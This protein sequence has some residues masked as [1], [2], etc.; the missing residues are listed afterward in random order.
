T[1]HPHCGCLARH[2]RIVARRGH[3]IGQRGHGAARIHLGLRALGLERIQDPGQLT[4]LVLVEAELEGEKAQRPSDAELR[5]LS[6][7]RMLFPPAAPGRRLP[8]LA[9]APAAAAR[10]RPAIRFPPAAPPPG[11]R[12]WIHRV[13]LSRGRSRSRRGLLAWASCLTPAPRVRRRREESI[14]V[15]GPI[16]GRAAPPTR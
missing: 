7:R 8:A 15:L 9:T 2:L 14:V 10:V 6:W 16:R 13:L 4:D 5:A 3:R 12:A 1:A 11:H